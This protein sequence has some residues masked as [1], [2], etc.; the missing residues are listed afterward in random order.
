MRQEL[1]VN[2]IASLLAFLV[3]WIG[4]NLVHHYRTRKPAA[5][6]W[7]LDRGR[8][9]VMVVGESR[10]G[11]SRYPKIP[12]A[13]ALAAMNLRQSLSQDLRIHEAAT[14]RASA[15]VMASDAE[16]NLVVIGGPAQ[17][18]VWRLLAD[19]LN[20]PFVFRQF[21][22]EY[23]IVSADGSDGAEEYGETAVDGTTLVDH[24]IVLLARNPFAARSR[25]VMVAG[26]GYLATVGATQLFTRGGIR[27]L[28]KGHDTASPL[29]L[30]VSVES[31]GGYV[32]RPVVVAAVNFI[33]APAGAA[34]A[35]QV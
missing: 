1:S 2:L 25:L 20:A 4:R 14:V 5:R 19:R 27:E 18:A 22:T 35:S 24:A 34:P 8:R 17:N 32:T 16:E 33:Q 21:P 28:A 29:A 9:V 11:S 30:V 12:E 13:D 10:S 7:R 15:F 3:G 31:V 23:R 6:V 26:C